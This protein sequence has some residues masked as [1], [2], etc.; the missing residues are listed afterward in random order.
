VAALDTVLGSA[1]PKDALTLW[2]L[3]SRGTAAE[4]AKVFDRMAVLAPPPPGVTRQ[5]VVD[6][7]P[8]ALDAWFNTLGLDS[9]SWWRFWKGP[10]KKL[11]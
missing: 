2:H 5:A 3:L 9:I 4:R 6:G 10:W 7:S 8:A 1:R 11:R